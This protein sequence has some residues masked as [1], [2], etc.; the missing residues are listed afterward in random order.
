MSQMY[1]GEHLI[2][3]K[4]NYKGKKANNGEVYAYENGQFLQSADS[5]EELKADLE[6]RFS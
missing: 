4:D 6:E 2:E 5:L 3:I 1:I